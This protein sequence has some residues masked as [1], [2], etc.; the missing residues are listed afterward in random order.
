MTRSKRKKNNVNNSNSDDSTHLVNIEEQNKQMDT[1]LQRLEQLESKLKQNGDANT[2]RLI[3][4]I[5]RLESTVFELQIEQDRLKREVKELKEERQILVEEVETTKSNLNFV[6]EKNNEL[7]QYNRG[8]NIRVFGIRDVKREEKAVETEKAV[9]ELIHNKLGYKLVDSDIEVAHRLG[10]Y[11]SNKDRAV[12]VRFNSRKVTEEVTSRRRAL[13]GSGIVIAEDL[14]KI[15]AARYQKVRELSGVVR[16][17]TRRGEIYALDQNGRVFKKT[18][19]MELSQFSRVLTDH[20]AQLPTRVCVR[21][22]PARCQPHDGSLLARS[23]PVRGL[24]RLRMRLETCPLYF[25]REGLCGLPSLVPRDHGHL[26]HDN[27]KKR[28]WG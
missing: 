6:I 7:E 22:P 19:S 4:S 2:E 26:P 27:W 9:R 10:S 13:K 23:G 12:I 5:Q 17:W 25:R 28:W 3:E 1:I 15:N 24:R 16:A 14:T 8:N 11:Q 21:D 18:P 20:I